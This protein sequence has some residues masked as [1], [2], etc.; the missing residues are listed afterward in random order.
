MTR[1]QVYR[2]LD[3]ERQ[4]QIENHGVQPRALDIMVDLMDDFMGKA[5]RARDAMAPATD[6]MEIVRE[7]TAIGVATMEYHGAP[8]RQR[9]V[10][11][12]RI[13]DAAA[14]IR[15]KIREKAE[16]VENAEPVTEIDSGF[17]GTAQAPAEEEEPVNLN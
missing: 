12:D 3:N 5:Q 13:H 2:L 14:K 8:D 1:Q 7:I 11:K 9:Q 16:T 17:S 10:A 6:I 15:E 4:Y